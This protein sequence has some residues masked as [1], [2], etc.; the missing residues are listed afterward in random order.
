MPVCQTYLPVPLAGE[1]LPSY[2]APAVLGLGLDVDS[3]RCL[4]HCARV[5]RLGGM[6]SL[7]DQS[8]S[9]SGCCSPWKGSCAARLGNWLETH[10]RVKMCDPSWRTE[11]SSSLLTCMMSFMVLQ[12][13]LITVL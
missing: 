10:C 11:S 13:K 4:E 2:T 8:F 6:L 12:D 1:L 7:L 9:C 5:S 3:T